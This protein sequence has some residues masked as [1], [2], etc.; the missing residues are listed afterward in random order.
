MV[1]DISR[2]LC[3]QETCD[4]RDCFLF[5]PYFP[6]WNCGIVHKMIEPISLELKQQYMSAS[7]LR[8]I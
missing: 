8:R 6:F 1:T 2:F 5:E 3:L 7:C 4:I